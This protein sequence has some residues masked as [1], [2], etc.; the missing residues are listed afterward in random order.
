MKSKTLLFVLCLVL[1]AKPK[2]EL[3][4]HNTFKDDK[5]IFNASPAVSKGQLFLRSDKYLYCIG[6]K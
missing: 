4:A 2:Y 6:K 5:S 1:A 3:L